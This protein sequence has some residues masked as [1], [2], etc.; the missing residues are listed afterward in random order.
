MNEPR[1]KTSKK[2]NVKPKEKGEKM[3]TA[4]KTNPPK[5]RPDT[6]PIPG[7]NFRYADSSKVGWYRHAVSLA[8]HPHWH[9][10][11]TDEKKRSAL[12]KE[13]YPFF[14]PVKTTPQPIAR[15]TPAM[16]AAAKEAYAKAPNAEVFKEILGQVESIRSRLVEMAG[17]KPRA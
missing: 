11:E 16:E 14:L 13:E 3:N 7:C 10:E 1:S 2:Q 4:T 5:V 8:L 9:P 12:F 6:C 15:V 17:V